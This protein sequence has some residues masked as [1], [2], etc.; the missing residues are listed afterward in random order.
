MRLRRRLE[1]KKSTGRLNCRP[2]P[3]DKT[4][5]KNLLVI[6]LA[7]ATMST[8]FVGCSS[9]NEV[10]ATDNE[11]VGTAPEGSQGARGKPP[12]PTKGITD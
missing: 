7:V 11:P 3:C 1:S 4:V 2:Y 10:E 12:T 9:G 8:V 5:M 6:L